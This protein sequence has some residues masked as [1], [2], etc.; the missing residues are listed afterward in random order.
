MKAVLKYRD[1][2]DDK[3]LVY[4]ILATNGIHIIKEKTGMGVYPKVTIRIKDYD[5]LNQ[6]VRELNEKSYYG[7]AVIKV[8]EKSFI[9]K[10][11]GK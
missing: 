1:N 5:E 7:V 2:C 11:F 10:L 9:E 8:F 6:L 4:G 3:R